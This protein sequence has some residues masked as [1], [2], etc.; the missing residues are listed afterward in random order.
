M[1][2]FLSGVG[3]HIS[4]TALHTS[5][6]YSGSVPVKLS[7]LYSK[8]KLPPSASASSLSNLAPSMAICLTSSLDFPNTC[9][10]CAKDVE[11]YTCTIA[12]GAPFTAS[13]VFFIICGLACVSTW[14]VTSSGII[15]FSMSVRQ[16][17][18]SVSDAAGNPI[19]ISLKPTS[20]S[21]LKNSSFSSRLI[22]STKAW[23]PSLKSTEHHI[24]ALSI[25]SFFT[26]SLHST[27]G[28]K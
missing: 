13:N 8:R 10:L 11:L 23:L 28:I 12:L 20:I 25:Y 3:C 14:I 1:I 27:G 24:G 19:S 7:G 18:Y 5:S 17:S 26:Q 6:A 9:S 16:S 2:H 15:F 22:G 4:I 21:L